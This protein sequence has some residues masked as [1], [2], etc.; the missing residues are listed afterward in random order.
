[1]VVAGPHPTAQSRWV[2]LLVLVLLII[3]FILLLVIVLVG[4]LIRLVWCRWGLIETDP[5]KWVIDIVLLLL[6]LLVS[7]HGGLLVVATL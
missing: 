6:L 7:L 5:P 4:V 1:L 2:G 3:V